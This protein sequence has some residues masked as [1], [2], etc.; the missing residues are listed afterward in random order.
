MLKRVLKIILIVLAIA[1]VAAQFVRPD[2][3]SKPVNPAESIATADDVPA[4]V[5]AIFARSCSDCHSFETHLP[6]YAEVAP[7]SWMLADHIAD[8]RG[9]LNLSLWNTYEP[10]RKNKKAAEVCEQVQAR[11]M[12]LPSYLWMHRDAVLSDDD[13]RTLCAWSDSVQGIK[14]P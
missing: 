5:K 7:F 13:I 8:G 10:R 4:E 1:F 2:L 9:E 14:T 11:K 12:P 6:W 3:S